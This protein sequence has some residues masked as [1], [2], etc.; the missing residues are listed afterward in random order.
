M[1]ELQRV[2]V[3]DD[4]KVN[5]QI[6]SDILK[7]DV[8]II[9][10]KSGKQGVRKAIE[11]QPD[12][13][14]LDVR[15]PEMD[16]FATMKILRHDVRTCKIPV[17][18]ITALNDP[19]YEEKGLQL[20]ASDYIHKPFYSS[21]VQARVRL[22]LR[23]IKQQKMLEQLAN[24]DSLTSLANRRKYQEAVAVEWNHAVHAREPLS[25]VVMDIDDFKQ[26]NDFHGHAAGD[27]LIQQ[28]AGVLSKLFSRPRDLVSRYGGEEFV[29]LLP[30]CTQDDVLDL[31]QQAI[32]QVEALTLTYHTN[33]NSSPVT[34][35]AG[36]AS[37][38]PSHNCQLDDFFNL[39]DE[40]LYIAKKEGKNRVLWTC[41][42]PEE[43]R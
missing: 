31:V 29:I 28:V 22:H 17:I 34:I 33:P 20:G 36:G 3:I 37:C 1:N 41:L 24:I 16:G 10:A 18:F 6:I 11:Y 27:L 7:D 14:L 2:L 21:I 43:Q 12:L 8:A 15:M 9:L 23:L 38:I 32:K 26:Y 39:A 5:L 40:T 13:I 30:A 35:S 25:L 19:S 4:E 42:E